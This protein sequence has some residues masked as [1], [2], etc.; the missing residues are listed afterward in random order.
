MTAPI[1]NN[2]AQSTDYDYPLDMGAGDDGWNDFD[3]GEMSIGGDDQ[4]LGE[5]EE[6]APLTLTSLRQGIRDLNDLLAISDLKPKHRAKIEAKIRE[7]Q[8]KVDSCLTMRPELQQ[9]V[10]A[11]IN[12]QVS[13]LQGDIM[14]PSEES[15][16]ADALTESMK[17][18][19]EKIKSNPNLTADKKTELDKKIA[20]LISNI[21][22]GAEGAELENISSQFE[23]IQKEYTEVSTHPA[24][25]S[26]LAELT[27]K[28]AGDI[29]KAAKQRG[30]DLSKPLPNPPTAEVIAFLADVSPKL[31][32]KLKKVADGVG[33]R[34]KDITKSVED[35]KK[36]NSAN[37]KCTS[38]SD[39]TD[40]TIFQ[41]LYDLKYHQDP[42]AKQ[43]A[44]DMKDA[45]G[46][47]VK[48]LKALY[49]SDAANIK[50]KDAP[51]G[52]DW[53]AVDQG[54]KDADTIVFGGTE[55][56]IFDNNNGALGANDTELNVEIV[57][58]QYDWE[59]DGDWEDRGGAPSVNNYGD[60]TPTT[61]VY[62]NG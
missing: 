62:D 21:E 46:E 32:E 29:E 17:S 48:L 38:D 49:P 25:A 33:E 56:D 3:G 14:N 23:A 18:L 37:T 42:A 54:F 11:T 16:A 30:L 1:K 4:Y 35:A 53:K 8:T 9:K 34:N 61:S 57:T 13:Q 52:T 45:N 59:G 58:I 2:Q 24:G 55:I 6:P 47:I 40:T 60:T 50:L 36:Q 19:Q 22:L 15:Q 28:S 43:I 7:L 31:A 26:S 5:G 39:N 51:V 27:G 41:K 12:Q 44:A 20:G 10:L